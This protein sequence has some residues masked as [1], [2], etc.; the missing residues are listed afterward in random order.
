MFAGAV[1]RAVGR[2]LVAYEIRR[3][4]RR[5]VASLAARGVALAVVAASC[6]LAAT[7]SAR[8]SAYQVNACSMASGWVNRAWSARVNNS[9]PGYNVTGTLQ[10]CSATDPQPFMRAKLQSVT[11]TSG[12]GS[13][14]WDA[15]SA[16][17]SLLPLPSGTSLQRLT[18]AVRC[19]DS[20]S[21]EG[22]V[23]AG[24]TQQRCQSATFAPVNL[25]AT[26]AALTAR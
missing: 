15:A 24:D 18:A 16:D 10:A 22:W 9:A 3:S 12:S 1:Q 13:A 14:A 4:N 17:W 20:G 25:T 8:A 7:P 6:G 23:I 11:T 26:G 5:R 2:C 21:T 19:N